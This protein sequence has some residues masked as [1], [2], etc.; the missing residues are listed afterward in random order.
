[1]ICS[2]LRSWVSR[3]VS[4]RVD[5]QHVVAPLGMRAQQK[6]VQRIQAVLHRGPRGRRQAGDAEL[7]AHRVQQFHRGQPRVEDVGDVAVRRHPVQEGAA[8]GGLAGADL[9]RQQHEAAAALQPIEQ[10]RQRLAVAL[11]H[12]QEAGIGRDRER[13]AGQPEALGVHRG[14]IAPARHRPGVC[15]PATGPGRGVCGSAVRPPQGQRP[16]AAV[17]AMGR[18]ATSSRRRTC[19]SAA[20]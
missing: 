18:A 11:A 8:D 6:G 16:R 9:A 2:S 5:D 17:R 3:L 12:E 20:A 15:A 14:S 4:R 19:C 1:M 10:V 7:V 13:L